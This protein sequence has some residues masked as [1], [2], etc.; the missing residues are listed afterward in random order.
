MD[1]AVAARIEGKLDLMN[2]RHL[3]FTDDMSDVKTRLNGHSERLNSMEAWRD[4]AEGMSSAVKLV[5]IVG[6]ALCGT[7]ITVAIAA[8]SYLTNGG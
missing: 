6:G 2:E 1:D 5:W 7:F 4:R 8:V 3:R